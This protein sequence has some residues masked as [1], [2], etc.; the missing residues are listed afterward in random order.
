MLIYLLINV[1]TNKN[2]VMK[3][4]KIKKLL[5]QHFI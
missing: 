1:R 2:K 5:I 3:N 4:N